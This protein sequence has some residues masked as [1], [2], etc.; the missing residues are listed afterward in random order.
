ME[1]QLK[2][3][4][5]DAFGYNEH[6][7]TLVIHLSNGQ[8]RVFVDVPQTVAYELAGATSPGTYYVNAI[9]TKFQMH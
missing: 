6:T 5:I 8:R 2:S 3:K 7:G 4:L 9:R 1:I